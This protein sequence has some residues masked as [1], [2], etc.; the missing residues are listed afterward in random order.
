MHILRT[1][2]PLLSLLFLAGSALLLFL[3]LLSSLPHPPLN[4]IFL[5]SAHPSIPHAP[6]L[7]HW[8]FYSVCPGTVSGKSINCPPSSAAVPILPQENFG[9]RENVPKDFLDARDKYYYLSKF[10]YAFL[11][12]GLF[13]N[14][15]AMG[16][17]GVGGCV[18][19][20]RAVGAGL[21][22]LAFWSVLLSACCLTAVV[23][24]AR[25]AFR[26]EGREA[27]VGV[28]VSYSWI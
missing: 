27:N 2:L 7:A 28:K 19:G 25:N 4:R 20:G 5:L 6:P 18:R 16:A 15:L 21:A 26:D 8:T 23:V 10:G 22:G 9:T 17:G 3:L 14:L 1:L 11:V 13:W 24:M 12:I